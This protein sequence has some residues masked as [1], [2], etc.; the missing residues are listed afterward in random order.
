MSSA[1]SS[2]IAFSSITTLIHP[3]S[4]VDISECSLIPRMNGP[5]SG[6]FS[7]LSIRN[8]YTRRKMNTR[9]RQGPPKTSLR[10]EVLSFIHTDFS[11]LPTN[12]PP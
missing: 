1:G 5:S 9:T 10:T 11:S 2:S 4:T 12:A 3:D 7:L 8:R 6:R